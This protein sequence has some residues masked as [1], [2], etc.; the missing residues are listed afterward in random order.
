MHSSW[1]SEVIFM[2]S[3]S[4]ASFWLLCGVDVSYETSPL[5]SVLHSP[6]P[7]KSLSD[8]SSLM[9][10]NHLRFGPPLLLFPGTSITITLLPTYSFSLLN[11]RQYYFNLLYCA[12]LDISPTFVVP[13]ILSFLIL[14]SLVTPLIRLNILI[15]PTSNFF[16]CAFFAISRRIQQHNGNGICVHEKRYHKLC[17]QT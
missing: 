3:S 17:I 1:V 10:S 11:T 5:H 12:F 14:S 7:E 8:K 4:S 16:S 13:L 9:L 2:N 15:S 6:P